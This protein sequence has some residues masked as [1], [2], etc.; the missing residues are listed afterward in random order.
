VSPTPEN[1]NR[2]GSGKTIAVDGIS[3][4]RGDESNSRGWGDVLGPAGS[5]QRRQTRKGSSAP[6]NT[7]RTHGRREKKRYTR[8]KLE[9]GKNPLNDNGGPWTRSKEHVKA[10]VASTEE[11]NADEAAPDYP[12]PTMYNR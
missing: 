12:L 3:K 11:K 9:H 4:K 6:G 1:G 5:E 10:N 7:V 2:I 8:A